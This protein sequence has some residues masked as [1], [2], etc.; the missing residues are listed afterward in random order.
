MCD[1]I[2]DEVGFSGLFESTLMNKQATICSA[3]F[4]YFV[5]LVS[6]GLKY[7]FLIK[8][9][10]APKEEDK[11]AFK[12]KSDMFNTFCNDLIY[13]G[14]FF[15]FL[16]LLMQIQVGTVFGAVITWIYLISEPLVL[17]GLLKDNFKIK[18]AGFAF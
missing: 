3:L 11:K 10:K 9:E 13:R 8:G 16:T 2:Q 15:L 17:V 6:V 5:Y 18:A 7:L 14:A 4:L 12:Q 1:S